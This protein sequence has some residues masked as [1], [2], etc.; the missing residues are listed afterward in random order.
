MPSLIGSPADGV[1]EALFGIAASLS[2][3]RSADVAILYLNLTLYLRPDF[4][5][6]RVLIASR[7]EAMAKYDLAN[8]IY[9]ASSP[10]RLLRD[11]QVQA[12]IND[13]RQGQI[14]PASPR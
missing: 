6:A 10:R 1:A 12:A 4:D 13:G 3:Q 5:L 14:K 9:R 7:Y 11:D 2:D 8:G